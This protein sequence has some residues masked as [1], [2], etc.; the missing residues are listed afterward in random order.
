MTKELKGNI[1]NFGR[2]LVTIKKW[3]SKIKY[4]IMGLSMDSTALNMYYHTDI[5]SQLSLFA[6]L[7]FVNSPTW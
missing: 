2:K 4:L 7:I 1:K 5:Y 6:D 3:K